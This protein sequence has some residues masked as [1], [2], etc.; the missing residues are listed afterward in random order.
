MNTIWEW[1]E[2]LDVVGLLRILEA[3]AYFDPQQYNGVFERELSDLLSRTTDATVR[4]EI[5]D[6][7][8]FDWSAYILNSLKRAGIRGDD[9]RQE[10]FHR[11]V[12]HLLVNPG[13]LLTGWQ[14]GKHGPLSRR[15]RAA[16]W[17]SIR[18][19]LEK[20]RNR[21]KW[22][23]NA[24]PVAIAERT[25][26]REPRNSEIIDV[27]R[28]LVRHRLGDLALKILDQRLAGRETKELIGIGMASAF[29]VKQAV[30][31]IKALA[32]HFATRI[33]DSKFADMVSRAMEREAAT[34]EKRKAATAARSA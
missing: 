4:Q 19:I 28:E 8:G 22:M 18:N 27:F 26:E 34:I 14:P 31:E 2:Q 25:P 33:G 32:D 7:Q 23:Q 20:R 16:T 17:N 3:A 9:Q 29:Y 1:I 11:T 10:D 24:D 15:F 5:F 21:R 6:L 12:V 30:G 13:K